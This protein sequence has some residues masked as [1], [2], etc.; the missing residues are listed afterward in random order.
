MLDIDGLEA[1]FDHVA[2]A[3]PSITASLP[4]F[5]DLLGGKFVGGGTNPMT[6]FRA[7]QLRYEGGGRI[8]LIEELDGS[9]F[10]RSFL[11]RHPAGGLHHLTFKVPD[12]NQA[13]EAVRG[14][15]IEP[16]GVYLENP[17][18]K[19][20]FLHPRSTGGTLVQLAQSGHE[21]DLEWVSPVSVEEF[22]EDPQRFS[23]WE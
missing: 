11:R 1:T 18:W 19:E 8:E 6:G 16:F 7:I 2:H 17:Y 12:I 13:I 9:G 5:R 4:I 15:G 21:W 20:M 22:L 3:T 14:A 10:L 23:T